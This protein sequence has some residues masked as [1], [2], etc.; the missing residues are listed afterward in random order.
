M[1]TVVIVAFVGVYSDR[2]SLFYVLLPIEQHFV[3]KRIVE[4]VAFDT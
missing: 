2:L 3:F 1:D 4:R